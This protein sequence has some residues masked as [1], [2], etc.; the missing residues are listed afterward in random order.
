MG[1]I[2]SGTFWQVLVPSMLAYVAA[3]AVHERG[4]SLSSPGTPW[5]TWQPSQGFPLWPRDIKGLSLEIGLLEL[6]PGNVYSLLYILHF[7]SQGVLGI[8]II[9]ISSFWIAK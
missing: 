9:C 8:C 2:D 7:V 5:C 3:T 1:K 4:A 6:Q